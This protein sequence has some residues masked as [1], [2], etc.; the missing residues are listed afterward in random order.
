MKNKVISA[1]PVRLQTLMTTGGRWARGYFPIGVTISTEVEGNSYKGRATNPAVRLD[2]ERIQRSAEEELKRLY[3]GSSRYGMEGHVC[4][5][6]AG[7]RWQGNDCL[8]PSFS[9]YLPLILSVFWA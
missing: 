7:Q 4:Y 3:C 2:E 9:A 1:M 6:P 8:P 5:F